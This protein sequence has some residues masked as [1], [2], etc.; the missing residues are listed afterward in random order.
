MHKEILRL[1]LLC[2]ALALPD[3]APAQERWATYSND[4]FGTTIDYP[5]RFRPG[6]PPDNNDGLSFTAADGATLSVWGSLNVMEHDVAGL[7][8]F[9]RESADRGTQFTYRAAGKN[10]LVLSGTR[11]DRVFYKRYAFSHRNEIVNAFEISYPATLAAAY[12]PIVARLSKSL[13]P[14]RGY[15]VK[16]TP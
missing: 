3:A 7:E 2:L 13:R 4:R 11:D 15:Q 9:L 12:D 6:R 14:A 10:W 8:T 16:G 1:A 5:S